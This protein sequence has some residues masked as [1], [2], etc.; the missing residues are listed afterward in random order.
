[1][2]ASGTTITPELH[3]EW[4]GVRDTGIGASESAGICGV[5]DHNTALSIYLRKVGLGEPRP[6][7]P[8][9]EWGLRHEP[10]IAL[11][12]SDRTG[13]G[14]KAEQVFIRHP[15]IAW[16]IATLDRVR[17]DGKLVELKTVGVQQAMH[18]GDQLGEDGSDVVPLEWRIQVTHQML[19][20]DKGHKEADIAALIGGNDFRV[21]T[22]GFDERV[23]SR[24][25]D[26]DREFWDHVLHRCPPPV[27]PDRD[28]PSLRL[29]YP[30]AVGE[31]ELPPEIGV[32]VAQWE[33]AKE[34]KNRATK[35]ADEWR[36]RLMAEMG[37][38][39]SGTLPDGRLLVRKIVNRKAYSVAASSHPEL[40]I[41]KGR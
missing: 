18:Y 34:R 24:M 35:E 10:T 28:G 21:Y 3:E 25:V 39:A 9:M 32:A 12:Y 31:I 37:G 41:T 29:L 7:T 16:L 4:L 14:F 27:N 1:M 13:M 11:A 20:D 2:I 5:D 26:Y 19:A 6:M 17:T 30:D 38:A 22:V 8:Q 23:A 40:R 36:D 15:G 33:D